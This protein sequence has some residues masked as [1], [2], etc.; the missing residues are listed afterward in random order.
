MAAST[1]PLRPHV[2]GR[3]NH[4]LS[5]LLI[6][7]ATV[8]AARVVAGLVQSV[9]QSRTGVAGSATI[10]VITRVVVLAMGLLVA[11]ETVGVSSACTP[12]RTPGSTSR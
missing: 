12:S 1:L 5:A 8:G 11:L 2:S 4:S 6:L 9:A 3:V 10:F 7:M